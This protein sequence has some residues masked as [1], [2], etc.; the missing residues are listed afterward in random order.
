MKLVVK[1]A[2]ELRVHQHEQVAQGF[3]ALEIVSL[4]CIGVVLLDQAEQ[5]GEHGVLEGVFG[6]AL[7]FECSAQQSFEFVRFPLRFAAATVGLPL[8]PEVF[9]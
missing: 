3:E 8:A 1:F 9:Q 2:L 6:D 5:I 4:R 7:F